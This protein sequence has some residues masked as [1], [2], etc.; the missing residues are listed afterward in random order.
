[1]P[2]GAQYNRPDESRKAYDSLRRGETIST[3]K[4]A[5]G[6]VKG[7]IYG[8]RFLGNTPNDFMSP[9]Y[10]SDNSISG[11]YKPT[12]VLLKGGKFGENG[13]RLRA[14]YDDKGAIAQIDVSSTADFDE[15]GNEK[16]VESHR[17]ANDI[18]KYFKTLE[19]ESGDY[20]VITPTG[21]TKRLNEFIPTTLLGSGAYGKPVNESSSKRWTLRNPSNKRAFEEYYRRYSK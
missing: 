9:E 5:E 2:Y 11:T 12:E 4:G 15:A 17:G 18:S 8:T 10:F 16:L 21:E 1:M 19:W 3:G 14:Y 7:G 20:S 6:D 13:V